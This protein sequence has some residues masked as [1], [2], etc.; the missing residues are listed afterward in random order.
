MS[1]EDAESEITSTESPSKC[2]E[3]CTWAAEGGEE[4]VQYALLLGRRQRKGI[5]Y[6]H[7]ETEHVAKTVTPEDL[8][9]YGGSRT[10]LEFEPPLSKQ[11]PIWRIPTQNPSKTSRFLGVNR[12]QQPCLRKRWSRDGADV[13]RASCPTLVARPHMYTQEVKISTQDV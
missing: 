13:Q 9:P 4:K 3:K 2:R 7:R 10:D 5:E 1:V 12:S 11:E 8:F 6:H